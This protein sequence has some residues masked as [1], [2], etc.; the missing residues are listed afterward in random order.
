[1]KAIGRMRHLGNVLAA[2]ALVGLAGCQH[3][4]SRPGAAPVTGWPQ[5]AK[6]DGP[7]TPAQEADVQI[8]MGREAEQ[9]GNLEQAM[10]AYRA[11]LTRDDRRAD[12]YLRMA[13]LSDK[14]GKFRESAEFYRKALARRPGDP[15]IYCDMGY[16]FYL[17]RRWAESEMNLRQAL[18]VNSQHRRAH[19]NLA[20][21]LVRNDRLE[22]ALAEFRKG[23]SDQV[24]AHTNL[25]FALTMDRRWDAARA[26]YQRVLERDPAS[27]VAR[28]RLD[29]LNALLAK[30]EP[31]RAGAAPGPAL[32]TTS[33][34]APPPRPARPT[35]TPPDASRSL[36]P[37][38]PALFTTAT[39][40]APPLRQAGIAVAGPPHPAQNNAQMDRWWVNDSAVGTAPRRLSGPATGAPRPLPDRPTPRPEPQAP[41]PQSRS[42]PWLAVAPPSQPTPSNPPSKRPIIPPP[43]PPKLPVTRPLDPPPTRSTSVPPPLHFP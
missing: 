29:Q 42:G 34:G 3:L 1:M 32:L 14:Q 15:D 30:L 40:V 33:T 10:A 35:A 24:Q 6:T 31:T 41:Q 27:K 43:R 8:S 9:Q 7:I 16:S 38:D 21:V 26:E 4:A 13:V 19:N 39:S 2:G 28:A 23:G 22:D 17:Q 5:A 36:A 11:A 20:L 25:A 37:R 18:A 12:A